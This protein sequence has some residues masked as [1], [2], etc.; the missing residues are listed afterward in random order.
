MK[1]RRIIKYI[2]LKI[3]WRDIC[4]FDISSNISKESTFERKCKIHSN[5]IFHGHLGLGSYIGINCCLSAHIGRF[6]SIAPYVKCNYGTHP[7][8]SPFVSTSPCFFSIKSCNDQSGF[9]YAK[10]DLFNEQRY[11]DE[12]NKIGVKIGSDCWIG[13]GVFLVGGI[14]IADG[15]VVLAHA[16]VTKNVPPYAIVG[17]IPAKVLRYR[18]DEETINFLLKIKWWN[19]S[20]EWFEEHWE[21]FS[22]IKKFREYFSKNE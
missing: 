1:L 10:R 15:A 2:Y 21:L 7:Y 22:N 19:K 8:Q 5:T 18:Y 14:E 11:Y 9:T 4:Q 6:S 12:K 17:G 3:K 13:E 16:V 20:P